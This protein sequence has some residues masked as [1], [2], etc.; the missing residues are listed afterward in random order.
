MSSTT[1]HSA[2]AD[3]RKD[4]ER[5]DP[6]NIQRLMERRLALASQLDDAERELRDAMEAW[7]RV[8]QASGLFPTQRSSEET[9]V[10]PAV[11]RPRTTT[12]F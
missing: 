8:T 9:T 6:K 4:L 2:D 11:V 3:Q 10:I 12:T 1:R 5:I 7:R